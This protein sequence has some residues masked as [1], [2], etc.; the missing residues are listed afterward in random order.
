MS[1]DAKSTRIIQ[2]LLVAILLLSILALLFARSMAVAS[3]PFT[4]VASVLAL[5]VD[6]YMYDVL[7]S[8]VKEGRE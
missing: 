2:G 3:R 1:Q 7:D 8:Q 4:S 6:G 5:L